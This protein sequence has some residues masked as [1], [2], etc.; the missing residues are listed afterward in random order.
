MQLGP[1]PSEATVRATL[2]VDRTRGGKESNLEPRQLGAAGADHHRGRCA[3]SPY[4]AAPPHGQPGQAAAERAAQRRWPNGGV[5]PEGYTFDSW[6]IARELPNS[7]TAPR[8]IHT[9]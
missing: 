3:L 1:R 9:E 5:R 2:Y 4:Q 8:V 7:G 6:V